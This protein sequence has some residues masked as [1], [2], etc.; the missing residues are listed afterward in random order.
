MD[1]EFVEWLARNAVPFVL[2]FTKTDKV[3]SAMVQANIAAF[4]AR[5]AGWFEKLPAIFTCSATTAQGRQEL[6]GVIDEA[7][8]AIQAESEP[9]TVSPEGLAGSRPESAGNPQKASRPRA[10]VVR[11]LRTATKIRADGHPPALFHRNKTATG[12]D[13]DFVQRAGCRRQIS[14]RATRRPRNCALQSAPRPPCPAFPAA[15]RQTH[16]I[17]VFLR[18]RFH[19]RDLMCRIPGRR[20][21]LPA[22]GAD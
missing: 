9:A 1:V 3:A 20:P 21:G 18:P 10:P 12:G 5:I 22:L 13:L 8:K 6:L 2:V 4:T 14:A 7:M 16:P 19:R 17:P 11:V 15:W